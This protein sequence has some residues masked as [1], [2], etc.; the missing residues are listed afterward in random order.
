[1]NESMDRRAARQVAS[2]AM[3][4]NSILPLCTMFACTVSVLGC[5]A[6]E[7]ADDE[8]ESVATTQ[9]AALISNA[10][11]SNALISNALISNALISNALISN[12][13]TSNALI[14]N[15]LTSSAL[16]DPNAREVL[17]YIV[18]CALP[19]DAK[20]NF[21][22]NGVDYSYPGALGLA[23]KWGNANGECN[24]ACQEWVSACVLARVN[25]LGQPV[26][27]SVRGDHPALTP[28]PAE[29][30]AYT[31]REGAYYGNLFLSTP[32]RDA[33]VAPARSG[34][35]RVCGPTLDGCVVKMIGGCTAVCEGSAG[36]GTFTNCAD[37]AKTNGQFPVGTHFYPT[38]VT[39]FLDP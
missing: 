20:V 5:I 13:L 36:Y 23:P 30:A 28:T 33:C 1:M 4:T 25:Y 10:L 14:S 39:V 35:P 17:K 38:A 9:E 21:T 29:I 7:G 8:T 26:S 15:A 24:T 22:V 12:S 31:Y 19:A 32:V 34:L 18:G 2:K 27:I 3:M 6:P 37:H 11:I 16:T